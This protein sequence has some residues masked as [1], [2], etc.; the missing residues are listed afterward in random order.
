MANE[1]SNKCLFDLTEHEILSQIY[2]THVYDK[3]KLD[4]LSLFT[5]AKNTLNRATS[6]VDKALSVWYHTYSF[7][8]IYR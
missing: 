3:E 2:A 7:E 4:V 5:M 1:K 6:A 8:Y